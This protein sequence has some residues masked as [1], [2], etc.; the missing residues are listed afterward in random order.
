MHVDPF[1]VTYL[2]GQDDM[3]EMECQKI[4]EA[5]KAYIA[6]VAV[7]DEKRDE[8][9]VAASANARLHLQSLLFKSKN[10]NMWFKLIQFTRRAI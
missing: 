7:C 9:S 2:V 3:D 4:E 1:N 6:A 10:F 5:R 8:E